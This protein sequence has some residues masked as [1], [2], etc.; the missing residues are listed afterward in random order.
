MPQ[1]YETN[2]KSFEHSEAQSV[3]IFVH[4]LLNDGPGDQSQKANGHEG[5]SSNL[6]RIHLPSN[7]VNLR[8]L[9]YDD[10]PKSF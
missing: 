10:S 1:W 6:V 9:L 7:C 8:I 3:S 4:H 2:S 5:D